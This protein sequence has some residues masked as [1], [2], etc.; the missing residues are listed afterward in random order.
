MRLRFAA[1]ERVKI[2][3]EGGG[4]R[5]GRLGSGRCIRRRCSIRCVGYGR[6][7]LTTFLL[8][9]VMVVTL[10]LRGTGD[11]ERTRASSRWGLWIC[12]GLLWGLIGLSNATP[13]LLLPVCGVWVIAGVRE[14]RRALA[15]AVVAA[16]IFVACLAPWT[17]RNW[18]VFHTFIPLRGNFGAELWVHNGPQDNGFPRGI[19][20]FSQP[21]LHELREHG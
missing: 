20:V 17:W 11:S 14:R 16:V 7:R 9:W 19:V 12:F 2:R 15:G 10:R 6:R 5:F 8:S 4:L 3:C 13:L 1:S 21:E 18:K